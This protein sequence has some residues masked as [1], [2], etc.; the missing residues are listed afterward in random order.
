MSD[1]KFFNYPSYGGMICENCGAVE[2]GKRAAQPCK[3]VEPGTAAPKKPYALPSEDACVAYVRHYNRGCR[4][5]ADSFGICPGS[6]LPCGNG[7]AAIR[8]VVKALRYGIE[9]GFI[10]EQET[11]G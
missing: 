3:W 7:E 11:K 5:C 1:H 8:F 10:N 6:G 9:H 2:G 4:D